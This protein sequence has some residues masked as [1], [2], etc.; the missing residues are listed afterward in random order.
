[1]AKRNYT[2]EEL[3]AILNSLE[4]I[5][6]AVPEPFL[7]TR[8]KARM[9]RTEDNVWSKMLQFVS[10]PAF[11][12]AAVFVFFLINGYIL[13]NQFKEATVPAPESAQTLAMEYASLTSTFY[14][15]IDEN[16]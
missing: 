4:G 2:D 13:F 1:M 14:E 12:L 6:K 7:Y 8:L 3:E 11:A 15:N 9:M 10:K 5:Q 16:P